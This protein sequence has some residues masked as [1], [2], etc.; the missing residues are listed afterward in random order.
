MKSLVAQ[1]EAAPGQEEQNKVQIADLK[2]E[3]SKAEGTC[4]Q[5]YQFNSKLL[6]L[7]IKNIQLFDSIFVNF[8][9]RRNKKRGDTALE[10]RLTIEG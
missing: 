4:F 8:R 3:L 9:K 2:S 5:Q 10:E 6:L 1:M 7:S